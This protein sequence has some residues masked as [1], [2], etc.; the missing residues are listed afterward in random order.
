MEIAINRHEP[1]E[2]KQSD[3]KF[4]HPLSTF[5]RGPEYTPLTKPRQSGIKRI[6][7]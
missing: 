2:N 1:M 6:S 5:H 3:P 7:E 4:C